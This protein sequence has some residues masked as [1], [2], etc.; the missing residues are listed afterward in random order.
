MKNIT[1]LIK[2]TT[3]IALLM[4]IALISSA[5]TKPAK[6]KEKEKPLQ[7]ITAFTGQVSGWVN[8]DDFV[9]TGLYLQTSSAKFL[10]NFPT[11]MGI[12]LTT[13][14]KT[15]NTIT[16]NGVEKT[17]SQ[18][19]KEIK[20]VSITANGTTINETPPV[21]PATPPAQ[22]FINGSGKISELQKDKQGKVKG[23]IL[24]NKTILRIP[25][26]VAQQLNT[27]A[28]AGSA[29]TYSGAKQVLHTGEVAVASYTVIH[30]KTITINGKQYLT[31]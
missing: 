12:E 1:A 7:E 19:E 14:I 23:Y 24:D 2:L 28:I 6:P 30:C 13:A 21:K 31:K 8:N 4:T 22:E 16:V 17:N 15:G 25:S 18:G 29:I 20:L 26:N 3:T 11:H 5:Q 9:Y 27:V 10:V